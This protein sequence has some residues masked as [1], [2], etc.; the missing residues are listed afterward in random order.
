MFRQNASE[1]TVKKNIS[2]QTIKITNNECNPL[3]DDSTEINTF[4]KFKK[5]LYPDLFSYQNGQ[6]G[7]KTKLYKFIIKIIYI[8]SVF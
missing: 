1:H 2:T 6:N 4:A 8:F 7:N 3:R 5:C